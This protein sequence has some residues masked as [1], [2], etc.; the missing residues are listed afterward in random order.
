MGKK[1]WQGVRDC[2]ETCA[3]STLRRDLGSR[4]AEGMADGPFDTFSPQVLLR[5][6]AAQDAR[7]C[8][9]HKVRFFVRGLGRRE[10]GGN[11]SGS[12]FPSMTLLL[13]ARRRQ[14]DIIG[15]RSC[16]ND[17]QRTQEFV[18]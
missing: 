6:G 10:D 4:T 1:H 11:S 8:Q 17:A 14:V 9:F 18:R 13:S 2:F 15:A 16:R 5:F 12:T 7:T 3:N